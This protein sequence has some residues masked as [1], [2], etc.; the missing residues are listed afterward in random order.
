[1]PSRY[2][3]CNHYWCLWRYF[4]IAS[5]FEQWKTSKRIVQREFIWDILKQSEVKYKKTKSRVSLR[6]DQQTGIWHFINIIIKN[7]FLY[8]MDSQDAH[9]PHFDISQL[10]SLI[11]NIFFS[12]YLKWWSIFQLM[13][14]KIWW[15]MVSCVKLP[16]ALFWVNKPDGS[17][18]QI[19]YNVR[20]TVQ[21]TLTQ[22]W[23]V[24]C[25]STKP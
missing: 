14:S 12:C 23:N 1:M 20:H 17:G 24:Q 11:P 3:M 25:R 18:Y 4:L 21:R 10:E 6:V 19:I 22:L 13:A 8:F 16:G 2:K 9:F 5:Y 15:N 7:F